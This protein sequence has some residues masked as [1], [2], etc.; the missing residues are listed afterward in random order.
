MSYA[1]AN[2][3][4]PQRLTQAGYSHAVSLNEVKSETQ[5]FVYSHVDLCSIIN[6]G[7]LSVRSSSA[8]ENTLRIKAG[9]ECSPLLVIE[10]KSSCLSVPSMSP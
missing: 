3:N 6:S 1:E 4:E 7:V 8:L 10:I 9:I 5:W 2:Y